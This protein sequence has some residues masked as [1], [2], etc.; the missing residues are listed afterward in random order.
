MSPDT[1]HI[2]D[3]SAA[4]RSSLEVLLRTYDLPVRS[5][6]SAGA[7]LAAEAYREPGC[8]VTDVRMPEM[9]GLELM[10]T[11]AERAIE[12][13]VIFI[14][15]HGDIK[16]AVNAMREGALDF[17]EKPIDDVRLVESIRRAF[18]ARDDKDRGRAE[19]AELV[20]RRSRL[21]LRETEVMALIVDG[22]S[23]HA[24]AAVLGISVRTVEHHRAAVMEKMAAHNLAKLIL[25]ALRLREGR[26]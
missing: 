15:G 3:D 21:T 13:P 23:N 9:T 14:S 10:R 17:I 19:M 11:L 4:V 22:F 25:M 8:L 1:V 7:Y 6:A 16:M 20:E 18:V 26:K 12:V 5:Y 2:V 24:A